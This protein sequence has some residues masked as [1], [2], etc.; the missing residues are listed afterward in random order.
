MRKRESEKWPNSDPWVGLYAASNAGGLNSN[1]DNLT[2]CFPSGD[3]GDGRG[4]QATSG[5]PEE[6]FEIPEAREPGGALFTASTQQQRDQQ[7]MKEPEIRN[8]LR[9]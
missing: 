8:C 9:K 3:S 4:F 7:N 5:R 2:Y 6:R 1:N